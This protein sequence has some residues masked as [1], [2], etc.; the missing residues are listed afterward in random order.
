MED[1]PIEELLSRV[2]RFASILGISRTDLK[3][4]SVLLLE[5]Q[6]TAREISEKMNIS[7]TKI[8]TILGKLEEKGWIKRLGKKPAFYE[9]V[10][11]RDLWANIK[12]TIEIK[13]D[14]FEKDFIEPLS[15]MLSTSSTYS[16]T[17]VPPSKLKTTI[18]EILDSPGKIMMAISFPE[19]L[20]KEIIEIIKVKSYNSDLK[21]ILQND[22]KISNVSSVNIRRLQNMFGS[23]IITSSAV[24][25]IV[26]NADKLSGLFSNHKYIVD[27]ASVYFNHL[28]EQAK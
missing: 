24:L 2:S 21:L 23:G 8:Y 15:S 12:K 1:N 28:W 26:K 13:I 19:I 16:I 17:M 20:E 5:G 18:F 9:A 22:I 4:Y 6:M 10:P 14:E 7:Y 27:I 25:L 11:L 3:I